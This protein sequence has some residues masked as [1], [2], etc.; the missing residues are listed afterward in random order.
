MLTLPFFVRSPSSPSPLVC[1]PPLY[2]PPS[3]AKQSGYWYLIAHSQVLEWSSPTMCTSLLKPTLTARLTFSRHFCSYTLTD[4]ADHESIGVSI[5]LH[6]FA[7]PLPSS[8]LPVVDV[9][10]R[11]FGS[12]QSSRPS[13]RPPSS[14]S[15]SPARWCTT[16]AGVEASN[17]GTPTITL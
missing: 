1:T 2:T 12:G 14:T 6:P 17:L 9:L 4:I 16:S 15:S 7:P 10:I 3:V 5:H 8:Q 13:P 11:V